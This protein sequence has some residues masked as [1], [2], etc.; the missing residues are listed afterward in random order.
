MPTTDLSQS[1]MSLATE[2]WTDEARAHFQGLPWLAPYV[3]TNDD[4]LAAFIADQTDPQ[5]AVREAKATIARLAGRYDDIVRGLDAILEG[6]SLLLTAPD[7]RAALDRARAELFP[8]GR[9]LI[10]RSIA[11]KAAEG[12]MLPGRLNVENRDILGRFSVNGFTL[13]TWIDDIFVPLA[14]Q[15]ADAHN[16]RLRIEAEASTRSRGFN[17]TTRRRFLQVEEALRSNIAVHGTPALHE[18]ILGIVDRMVVQAERRAAARRA[19]LAAGRAVAELDD[20]DAEE[21][22]EV[23]PAADPAA[24]PGIPVS[25]SGSGGA[26]PVVPNIPLP[27]AGA[28]GAP[29]APVS[30]KA[31]SPTLVPRAGEG[32]DGGKE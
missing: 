31:A 1:E 29:A 2:Y 6:H 27:I 15:L 16:D 10:T 5:A 19:A 30:T 3:Q 17:L 7:D 32:E 25:G 22:D 9:N 23:S 12:R 18:A 13:N 28:P 14:E 4:L 26:L 8:E 20:I 11:E 24:G 21:G